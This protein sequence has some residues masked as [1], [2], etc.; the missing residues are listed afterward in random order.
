VSGNAPA[1]GPA[2]ARFGAALEAVV[3]ALG[4]LTGAA[5]IAYA[6][7]GLAVARR[8]QA[9]G[10]SWRDTMSA[11]PRDQ[12]LASG[13][14]EL[15]YSLLGALLVLLTGSVFVLI[16][17]TIA[18]RR[19]PDGRARLIDQPARV[20]LAVVTVFL[21]LSMFAVPFNAVGLICTAVVAGLSLWL[22]AVL[23]PLI[24]YDELDA[25]RRDLLG[26]PGSRGWS[27]RPLGWIA[28]LMASIIVVLSVGRIWSFPQGFQTATVTVDGSKRPVD[29]LLYIG[30]GSQ[31]VVLGTQARPR[32]VIFLRSDS[33]KRLDLAGGPAAT[34]SRSLASRLGL[35]P[36]TS[37]DFTFRTDP[38]SGPAQ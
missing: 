34:F 37:F 23:K 7:G 3:K 16:V 14:I 12:I 6:L 18:A 26:R 22:Y 24:T 17:Q 33:V 1:T 13:T 27:H 36:L 2:T 35:V 38:P 31:Y 15:G 29:D 25:F 9:A 32:H 10:L 4:A 8:L 19:K 21:V 5:A 28:F 11:L 30:T 20:L